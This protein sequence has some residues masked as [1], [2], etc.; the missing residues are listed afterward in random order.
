[1]FKKLKND[2]SIH[3]CD[4]DKNIGPAEIGKQVY[5]K[6]VYEEH[7]TSNTYSR[8]NEKECKEFNNETRIKVKRLFHDTCGIPQAELTYLTRA[9][10]SMKRTHQLYGLPKLHKNPLAWRPTI[11]CVCGELEAV[12]KWLDFQ[13]RR[14]TKQVPTYLRE[15]QEAVDF[16]RAMGALPI[17][18]RLF[19]SDTTAMYTNI[20]PAVGIAAVKAWLTD[21]VTELPKGFPSQIVLETLELVMTR[22]TFQFDDIFFQQFFRTT[23]GTPCACV[24]ATVSYG[25]HERQ[26]VTSR[27]SKKVLPYLKMFIEDMLGIWCGTD[28]EWELFKSS[29]DGFGKLKW[30]TSDR[31]SQMTFLDLT[32]TTDSS[33]RHITTKTYQNRK[34]FTCTF[35]QHQHTKMPVSRAQSWET[36]SGTGIKT[37]APQ[38]LAPCSNN[39][40]IDCLTAATKREQSCTEYRKRRNMWMRT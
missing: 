33:S 9:R 14:I 28:D 30:I 20:E 32:I 27:L 39:S 15:S 31:A 6:Q 40:R 38:T 18:A 12:S 10:I 2:P 22:N 3:I 17:H 37:Q 35:H 24:Y 26:H 4:T 13:L 19:T 29:L 16:L 34:I 8:M 21:Y 25:Y 5:L 7:L 11:S 36:S 1:V 23:M